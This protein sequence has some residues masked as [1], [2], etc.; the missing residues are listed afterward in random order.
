MYKASFNSFSFGC[1]VNQ[2]ELETLNQSLIN[3]GFTYSKTNP[4]I[5]II[6]TCAVTAKA[7]REARQLIYSIKNKY[8]DTF[9]VVTG[10]SA[11]YWLKNKG[12]ANLPVDK[13]V[14]NKNKKKILDL[15]SLI[16]E[17]RKSNG[18][19]QTLIN[20]YQQSNRLLLKIQDGCQRFCSYCIVPYL[21]GKPESKTIAEIIKEIKK[22]IETKEI[23]LTAINT[24][25]YGVDS[26][27]SL[28]QLV[29]Q[30][31]KKTDIKRL[32]FGSINPWSINYEFV[33]L[34]KKLAGQGRF[35]DFFHIPL[36]SGSDKILKLM[37]R[38]YD[39]EYFLDK[40]NKIRSIYDL[41]LIATDVIVGFLGETDKDFED[42]YKFLEKSPIDKFHVFRFSR[43]LNTAAHH[44]ASRLQEPSDDIK[45]ARSKA[46]IELSNKKYSD[47]LKK[48][49]F[50]SF[51]ALFIDK[52]TS[53][54]QFALLDNQVKASIKVNKN[55]SGTIR[56]VKINKLLKGKLIGELVDDTGLEPVTFTMSM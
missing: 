41:A 30:V 21:R 25:A 8:P 42:T 47:F 23:I 34:Y 19:K 15:L 45:K 22:Q 51:K 2:A 54:Y 20:K 32:S 26:N 24:E 33:S 27:E 7:E 10:C 50:Q 31:L 55:L 35:I 16:F 17:E 1:R 43:R 40:I 49:I 46:L 14:S 3:K 12:L 13:V 6:N 37:K 44:M 11:T 48:H 29:K 9:L 39:T 28:T 53:G 56:K 18:L 52:P 4:N 5:Y 38:G 36:Q